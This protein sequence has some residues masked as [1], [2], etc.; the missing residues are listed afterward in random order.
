MGYYMFAYGVNT[1]ELQATF[2]SKNETLLTEVQKN[3]IFQNYAE[4]DDDNETTKALADIIMGRPF[5]EKKGYAYGYAFIGICAT[6]G[7]E[8]PFTQ[9]MKFWYE[10]D[11]INRTLSEDY[12]IEIA[13]DTELF[14]E[15]HFHS[16]PLPKIEDFPMISL[17]D[18]DRLKH[19]ASLLEKVHKTKEEV[20]AMID[21][22]E[23]DDEEK[24]FAYEHI[25]GLKENIAFCLS[26]QL[27]MI[28]FCH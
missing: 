26:N 23:E 12:D 4:E 9:E 20:E 5:D 8:L 13:I 27:D 1:P 28:A 25:M 24:G 14:P 18:Q 7:K 17:I 11:L 6:L 10:T 19:L 15:D 2:A 3:E 22:E 16:F 21:G